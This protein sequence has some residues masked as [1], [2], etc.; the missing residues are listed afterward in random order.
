MVPVS[1]GGGGVVTAIRHL[2]GFWFS[3]KLRGN[4]GQAGALADGRSGVDGLGTVGCQD[5]SVFPD[6]ACDGQTSLV[7]HGFCECQLKRNTKKESVQLMKLQRPGL[8]QIG[9]MGQNFG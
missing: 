6:A 4:Q 9:V 5:S 8:L 1:V 3:R 7:P 2:G